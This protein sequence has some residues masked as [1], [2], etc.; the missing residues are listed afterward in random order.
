M[1][2]PNAVRIDSVQS[3]SWRALCSRRDLVAN[4]GVVAWLEGE[5][6]ALFHLPDT[7]TG[8]Q[9]FAISNKDP[10]SGANVI[11]RGIL[12]QLKGDLVIASPLYKQHFRLADGSCLEYPEQQLQVWPARLN[13]DAVEIAA[14]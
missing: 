8:E 3:A 12:G 1:S 4:S 6:V 11:G 5:Q 13:G 10:K 9:V 14:V 7:E 2:Q